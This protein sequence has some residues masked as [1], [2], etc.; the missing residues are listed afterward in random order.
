[1]RVKRAKTYKR[2]MTA[3]TKTFGFREPYQVLADGNFIQVIGIMKTK[4]E[5][6]L[7]KVLGGKVKL[8]T[9][10]CVT[11]ELKSLGKDFFQSFIVSKNLE[12]RE[13]NQHK[14]CV[15]TQDHALRLQFRK[16]PGVPMIYINNSVVIL[17]PVSS[18]TQKRIQEIEKGKILPKVA[19]K[20]IEKLKTKADPTPLPPPPPPRKKKAKG[21][22]PLSVKKKKTETKRPKTNDDKTKKDSSN[23]NEHTPSNT[24]EDTAK[25]SQPPKPTIAE[26]KRK[27]DSEDEALESA[28]PTT[29]KAQQEQESDSNDN[30]AANPDARAPAKKKHKRRR[31]KKKSG[32][33]SA[34]G[35]NANVDGGRQ[36]DGSTSD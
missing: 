33:A 10:N 26:K 23:V 9:T 4:M 24:N 31:G 27:R 36:D 28:T 15:A 18:A 8:M 3:Y 17:E 6:A 25:T 35:Q 32:G 14:Y 29:K 30:A 22:N 20:E 1:M 11:A 16:I 21:P 19:V 5:D 13:T 2:F 7:P 34:G 12:K